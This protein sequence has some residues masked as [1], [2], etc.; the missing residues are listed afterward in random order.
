MWNGQQGTSKVQK[1]ALTN[2]IGVAIILL[3][4][5]QMG[6]YFLTITGFGI[7]PYEG[8]VELERVYAVSPTINLKRPKK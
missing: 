2:A 8:I 7:K 6:T 1:V 3:E 4:P 5:T